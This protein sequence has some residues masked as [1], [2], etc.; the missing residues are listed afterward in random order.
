MQEAWTDSEVHCGFISIGD[1]TCKLNSLC[2]ID[3]FM[4][5]CYLVTTSSLFLPL[6]DIG[7]EEDCLTPEQPEEM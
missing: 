3:I 6:C 4:S 7:A 5:A 1:R 2:S